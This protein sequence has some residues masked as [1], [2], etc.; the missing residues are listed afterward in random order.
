MKQ[1]ANPKVISVREGFVFIL[2]ALIGAFAITY[3]LVEGPGFTDAFYHFNAAQQLVTGQGLTDEYLWHYI[4]APDSLP[5]PSHLY[6]MPLTSLSA[7]LGMWLFNAPGNYAAAQVPFALMLTG[8]VYIAFWLGERLGKTRRHAWLAGL[9]TLTG[10]FFARFW[11][12]T[13]TFA[14]YGLVGALCLLL[15]GLALE[16]EHHSYLYWGLAGGLAGLGHLSRAD[17]LLLL[18]AGWA[19]ILWPFYRSKPTRQDAPS[20]PQRIL[21]LAVMTAVYLLVMA[22]WFV[23]S[24]NLTGSPLPVGGAQGIWFTRYD[25][26]FNYPPDSNAATFFADGIGL[27]FQTR[28]EALTGNLGTLIVVE[29]MIVLFPLMLVALWRRRAA[30]FLRG[31]WLY[32]LGLHL[33]MTLV[34]P[35]PGVR[36]GLFHSAA[37]LLPWWMALGVVGLDDVVDW[38]A[39]QRRQWK[40]SVAKRVFSVALV[41]FALVLTLSVTLPR[42]ASIDTPLLYEAL[43]A[44]LPDEARVMIN[45]PAQ[46]FYYTGFG[47]VVLPNEAPP[48]IQEIARQYDIDFVVLESVEGEDGHTVWAIS[49]KLLPI[50]DDLPDFLME[51]AIDVPGV[52]LYAIEAA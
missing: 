40:P 15:I 38:I 6:W 17:G 51:V 29:G 44:Q 4:G 50:L 18:I 14:P 9:L 34:F 45:D 52:K 31:F 43:S 27:L 48:V 47:G 39:R 2:I 32:A 20:L 7:A 8:I 3:G 23:R 1:S 11:G 16:T 30:P 13:D 10:G 25:D 24:V 19:A 36:G 33:A 37:A 28:W 12:A 46:L 49:D 21:A 22:P 41:M 5:A 42:R 26:L 35:F